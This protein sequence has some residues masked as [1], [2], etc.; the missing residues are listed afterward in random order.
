MTYESHYPSV[1]D[2][3]TCKASSAYDNAWDVYDPALSLV[4][5]WT[6]NDW[7]NG[8]GEGNDYPYKLNVDLGSAKIVRR[9]YYEN[10]H[11]SGGLTS[12]GANAVRIY[13]T[14]SAAA[15]ASTIVTDTNN[16]TLLHS[17]S[18][19]EHVAS[20]VPDPQY[21]LITND[22]AY[23]YY[24][25]FLDSGHSTDAY[26]GIR[27]L[28]YQVEDALLPRLAFIDMPYKMPL[29]HEMVMSYSLK[30]LLSVVQYYGDVPVLQKILKQYYGDAPALF[31]AMEMR[32]GDLLM[33]R[34][35]VQMDYHIFKPL[36]AIIEARYGI[37]GVSL[38]AMMEQGYNLSE[39]HLLCK[40]LDMPYLLQADVEV[41][42][43]DISLVINGVAVAFNHL[44]IEASQSNFVITG[45]AH[46]AELAEY[47]E[48]E[49]GDSA[50]ATVFGT[51]YTFI[52]ESKKR[53]RPGGAK[54]TFVVSF[55]SPAIML[56]APWSKTLSE[57]F[58]PATAEA[59]INDLAGDL[60][61]VDYQTVVFPVLA[62]TLY[63]N[64][65]DRRTVIRKLT[66]SVGAVMQSNPDGTIR[67]EPEYPVAVPAWSEVAPA[68]FLTDE[69]NFISQD[70]TPVQNSGENRYLISN[71]LSSSERIWTEQERVSG[72]EVRV[73]GFQVPWDAALQVELVHTGGE[74]VHVPE[75]MGV[76][77]ELYPPL[78]NEDGNPQPGEQIEFV[79]G[80]ANAS[81]AVYGGLQVEWLREQLGVISYA[82]DGKLEAELKAGS[83]DGYSL[84]EIRYLTRYHLWLARNDVS[85]SVQYLLRVEE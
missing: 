18:M 77:E 66:R 12:A 49:R 52:V 48:I 37:N 20:N 59:I 26:V 44:N 74:N 43:V 25:L 51:V 55:V 82:E 42:Q 16:L 45:E 73:L 62:D 11:N 3:T 13:G 30:M 15:F 2:G 39:Y 8:V 47:L 32:Y 56:T 63:A 46:L 83:T 76:V 57:E 65:E 29:Q 71:E 22:V 17:F 70:E 34:K 36:Q 40:K 60:A 80:Y 24:I 50:T 27:R 64:D 85:E 79:A 53:S 23:R 28:E 33:H 21:E 9:L 19:V 58:A 67:V 78:L 1:F 41:N 68:Y 7:M 69:R 75:Y 84:A 5:G 6:T 54:T 81:R 35:S 4:G 14:N 38:L 31:R 61:P 10:L 72:R